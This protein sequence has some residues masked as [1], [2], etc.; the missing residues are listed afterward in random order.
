M[1]FRRWLK[2]S[3]KKSTAGRRN[4]HN[5][6]GGWEM[7]GYP[8]SYCANSTEIALQKESCREKN[9]KLQ[10]VWE[11]KK[12][13]SLNLDGRVLKSTLKH[14]EKTKQKGAG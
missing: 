2:S 11:K 8:S 9:S 12:M 13:S 10:W 7:V 1:R 4:V 3:N 5:S 14:L 6:K